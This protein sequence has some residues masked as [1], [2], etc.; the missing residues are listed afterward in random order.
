MSNEAAVADEQSWTPE[1]RSRTRR[2]ALAGGVGTMIEYYDFGLYGYLAVVVAPLFFPSTDPVVSLLA[3]LAVFGSAF[4]IRPVGGVVFGHIGDRYGRRRALVVTLVVMGVASTALGLLPTYSQIGVVA[5]VLLVLIRLLQG[6]SAGGEVGGAATF[7][8]ESTP[9]RLRAFYGSF[10]PLGATAGFA[11]AASVAGGV[12]ALTTD[13]QMTAW[14]WRIPFLLALPL[15]LFCLWMRTR[16]AETHPGP[17][18]R[19]GSPLAAVVRH[20]GVAL[21]QASMVSVAVQASSYIGL[22]YM[23]IHLIQR[24]EYP[25]ASVYWTATVVIG[26]TAVLTA[27]GGLLGDRIGANRIMVIGLVGFLLLSIPVFALLDGGLALAGLAYLLFMVAAIAVQVGAYAM[28]PRL[29]HPDTRYTGVAIGWNVGSVLAGGTAP[30]AAVWLIERT[31]SVVAP[32]WFVMAAAAVGLGGALW[33]RR[34][35][36]SR[37]VVG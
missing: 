34:T 23:S 7:I 20:G 36:G 29:F 4:L 22:T 3:S 28:V 35:A 15:T 6:F 16:V 37:S 8:S 11:V 30:F 9:A 18:R 1:D 14:G 13:E 27:V 2:A 17:E 33:I 12:S 19:T 26:V 25:P 5:T 21:A 10:T 31:G 32:A 24:L